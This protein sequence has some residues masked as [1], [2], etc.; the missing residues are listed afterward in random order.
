MNKQI[1]LFTDGACLGNPGAGGWAGILCYNN[2]KKIISGGEPNTTNNRMELT[3]VIMGLSALTRS[4]EIKVVTDSRYVM[5][6]TQKWMAN[7]KKNDWKTAAK[8]PVKNQ[9]LWLQLDNLC[10]KHTVNWEWI[11]GHSGHAENE[12]CDQISQTEAKKIQAK[13]V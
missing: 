9:D 3:A 13:T 1:I 12:E 6:G 4:V 5:D 2:H 10:T 11:K 8:K 7:W